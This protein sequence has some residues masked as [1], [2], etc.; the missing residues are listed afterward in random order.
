MSLQMSSVCS[1][2]RTVWRP[3]TSKARL[4]NA[5]GFSAHV[6]VIHATDQPESCDETSTLLRVATITTKVISN[7]PWAKQST[8]SIP[9]RALKLLRHQAI[10]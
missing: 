10:P 8:T 9:C 2:P 7:L 5:P 3:S 4:A 6:Y 1:Y